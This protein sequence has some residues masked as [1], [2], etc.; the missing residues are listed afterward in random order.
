MLL[1]FCVFVF[2]VFVFLGMLHFLYGTI[3]MKMKKSLLLLSGLPEKGY[4]LSYCNALASW[5][6]AMMMREASVPANGWKED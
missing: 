3:R 2:C 5:R 6:S 4:P 1:C